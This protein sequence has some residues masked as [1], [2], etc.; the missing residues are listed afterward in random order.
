MSLAIEKIVKSAKVSRS[1]AYKVLAGDD[2]VA[3]ETR[4]RVLMAIS[5]EGEPELRKRRRPVKRLAVWLPGLGELLNRAH[6]RAVVQALEETVAKKDLSLEIISIPVPKE[7]SDAVAVIEQAK[8]RG[9]LLVSVYSSGVRTA[10]TEKWPVVLFFE[11]GRGERL[12][13]VLPDD[14]TA[15]FLA[16]KHLLEHGHRRIAVVVGAGNRPVGFSKRFVGGYALAFSEAGLVVDN[17]LIMRDRGNLGPFNGNG[18]VPPAGAAFLSLDPRPTAIVGRG[19]SVVG[20]MRVLVQ[21]GLRVPE[22]VSIVGYGP[23][24]QPEHISPELTRVEYSPQE[25]VETALNVLIA[26]NPVC[27]AVTI[28]VHLETGG[29]VTECL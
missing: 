25:M 20:V 4:D 9:V 27:A 22:D 29:S 15:G 16:T 19:E 24:G 17:A 13:N 10:L 1:T 7:P 8:V 14:F 18:G 2:R 5:R 6:H 28:S 11:P 3:G 12:A 26:P 23:A 21:A